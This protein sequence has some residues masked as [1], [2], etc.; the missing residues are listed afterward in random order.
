MQDFSEKKLEREDERQPIEHNVMRCREGK[1]DSLR[2]RGRLGLQ[3]AEPD[4]FWIELSGFSEKWN[5][6]PRGTNENLSWLPDKV[7]AKYAYTIE[8]R[9]VM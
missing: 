1:G 3:E 7:L 5:K 9:R 2:I 6:L 4:E 8:G